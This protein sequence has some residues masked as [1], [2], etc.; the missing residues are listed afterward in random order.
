MRVKD[1][2][3]IITTGAEARENTIFH[4]FTIHALLRLSHDLSS[5]QNALLFSDLQL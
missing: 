1:E 3:Y 4:R 2:D 5:P